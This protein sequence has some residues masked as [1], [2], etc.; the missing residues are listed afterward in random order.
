MPILTVRLAQ[1]SLPV[2]AGATVAIWKRQNSTVGAVVPGPVTYAFTD[3]AGEAAVTL[4]E[5]VAGEVYE[6]RLVILGD[7]RLQATFVMPD[8]AAYLDTL[9]LTTTDDVPAPATPVVAGLSGLT[10]V[11]G[12]EE[13]FKGL[14]LTVAELRTLV[15][16]DNVTI[17][18]VGDTIVIQASGAGATGAAGTNGTNGTNGL[19]A[20]EIAQAEGFAGTLS[21]WLD[22]LRGD[23]GIQ[24]E[25]GN[26][27]TA[28][29]SAY[30]LAVALGYIGTELDWILSLKGVKGDTG[31][32]GA[33]GAT[34]AAGTNG[35]NGTNGING[36]NGSSAYQI[37]VT[38]GFIG[39]EAEWLTSLVGDSGL[40]PWD[41]SVETVICEYPLNETDANI[42]AAGFAG[43]PTLTVS[44]SMASYIMQS[45]LAAEE[46]YVARGA[47]L[48]SVPVNVDTKV[49][50]WD[51]ASEALTGEAATYALKLRFGLIDKTTPANVVGVLEFELQ[52]DGTKL[53]RLITDLGTSADV[54]L[55]AMPA[56]V[57]M[58]FNSVAGTI[59]VRLDDVSQ[60]FS[61]STYTATSDATPEIRISENAAA[62]VAFLGKA[63]SV[64]QYMAAGD[65]TGTH[66]AGAKDVCGHI[67]NDAAVPAGPN[68]V[69]IVSV[70]G[71]YQGSSYGV[72]DILVLQGDGVTVSLIGSYTELLAHIAAINPHPQYTTDAEASAIAGALDTVLSNAFVALF[73]AANGLATLNGSSVI[74]DAQ[75]PSYVYANLAAFPPVGASGKIYCALDTGKLY[76]PVAGPAYQEVSAGLSAIASMTMLGNNTG[77][78]A[79]PTALTGPQAR[80][81]TKLSHEKFTDYTPA[82][83]NAVSGTGNYGAG[84]DIQ[85][86]GGTQIQVIAVS[87]FN[88]NAGIANANKVIVVAATTAALGNATDGA[89]IASASCTL[90]GGSATPLVQSA[91]MA[92]LSCAING[93]LVSSAY[94][95]VIIG[96][97][98]CTQTGNAGTLHAHINSYGVSD[99]STGH[100][101]SAVGVGGGGLTISGAISNVNCFGVLGAST[102]SA[103]N[104]GI[105]GGS[106]TIA[107]TAATIFG[108]QGAQLLGGGTVIGG[109]SNG[110]TSGAGASHSVIVGGNNSELSG[111]HAII[112]GGSYGRSGGAYSTLLPSQWHASGDIPSLGES[113]ATGRYARVSIADPT[114]AIRDVELL[115]VRRTTDATVSRLYVP[116]TT[117]AQEIKRSLATISQ[118]SALVIEVE[119]FAETDTGSETLYRKIRAVFNGLRNTT[120][121]QVGATAVLD[122]VYSGAANLW[123]TAFF[124]NTASPWGIQVDVTGVAATTISWTSR[125]K[126]LQNIHN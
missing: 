46:I 80:A 33:A 66:A 114:A 124:A 79:V 7:V 81:V 95:R 87:D 68:A 37:A 104:S 101:V 14:A 76:T 40:T 56:R 116:E 42:I 85:L 121:V 49:M 9:E 48:P 47:T 77:G 70:A 10:N 126:V 86:T 31:D 93:S 115:A 69:L 100:Y 12:G 21:Q 72:G 4:A 60:A 3:V 119:I 125:W 17:T 52:G 39:T 5:S 75:V 65:I 91:I 109:F 57:S 67:I 36:T 45:A 1:L 38:N 113:F 111:N 53:L 11:G 122:E 43:T 88:S 112:L 25:T 13:L 102:I 18:T 64:H 16:G 50:E 2:V 120:A 58:A 105:F 30:A 108:C 73:G 51:L 8:I 27:G 94:T 41:M 82:V 15:A 98:T 62:P 55:G 103:S 117:T 20:F 92:S 34:G 19:T 123:G 90:G 22:S 110:S 35:T 24:G 107:N 59:A 118:Q 83:A 54:T 6:I 78:S 26:A 74:P 71:A 97:N 23:Q 63:F 28:G 29:Q 84:N 32:T 89:I 96:G 99:S 44:S 106:G 61:A